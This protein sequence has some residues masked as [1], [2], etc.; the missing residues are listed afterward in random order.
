MVRNKNISG[1]VVFYYCVS[2]QSLMKGLR[3]LCDD[4]D[5][6][7]M[8][9]NLKEHK[10]V[11]VY[12]VDECDNEEGFINEVDD[13]ECEEDNSEES[14][15]EE[16][17]EKGD[18]EQSIAGSLDH[19]SCDDEEL[20]SVRIKHLK[21]RGIDF[22]PP[23]CVV[24]EAGVLVEVGEYSNPRVDELQTHPI[25]T[26]IP[27]DDDQNSECNSFN[28]LHSPKRHGDDYE[29]D[30]TQTNHITWDP[31]SDPFTTVFVKGMK[32][33]DAAT[34][35]EIITC[36]AVRNGYGI[37]YEK[38]STQVVHARCEGKCEFRLFANW[39]SNENSFQIKSVTPKHSCFRVKEIKI[40]HSE[41]L[42]KYFRDE[43]L[44][45]PKW[46]V[47]DFVKE[48]KL[49]YNIE[50]SHTKC[51]VAKKIVL[52]EMY[53]SLKN[54]YALLW[55]YS[56]ELRRSNPDGTFKIECEGGGEG[57]VPIFKRFYVG[58]SALSKG[59][60][61]GCRPIIGID[62]CF[63]KGS[64]KGEILAAVG[65]DANNQLFPIAWAVVEVESKDSWCWF[66]RYLME[67]I[68]CCEDGNGLTIC[69]DQQKGLIQA[70]AELLPLAEHRNCARHI[71]ENF[72]KNF[73]GVNL[74]L[75]FWIAARAGTE[76]EWKI[77]MAAIKRVT[78]R[79][80]LY[81]T[82]THN[83]K[84]WAR[85]F[86]Q[87]HCVCEAVEN[88]MSECFNAAIIE[89]RFKLIVDMLEDIRLYVCERMNRQRKK[90]EKW[91]D[92]LC[93]QIRMKLEDNKEKQRFWTSYPF[94]DGLYEVK[95]RT[96]GFIVNFRKKSCTCRMWNLS[97][98]PCPHAIS[99]IYHERKQPEDFVSDWLKKEKH[100]KAYA[101]FMKPING[102]LLWPLCNK[103]ILP[104]FI[105]K[106]P[107]RPKNKR[108]KSA[109]E[110]SSQARN[111]GTQPLTQ[112]TEETLPTQETLPRVG[113]LGEI[114]KCKIC[115]EPGHNRTTCP[116]KGTPSQGS[117]VSSL[118]HI[119][120]HVE[121]FLIFS[122]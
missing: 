84:Y 51:R 10:F 7:E 111:G 70:V 95:H 85:A 96:D 5:C 69:S 90:A 59:W 35:K 110:Q 37:W 118:L 73:T 64:V 92:D 23:N 52:S 106:Q 9:D 11:E 100:T 119:Y 79:G 78:P 114:K 89:A 113:R 50:V 116:G 18:E 115:K 58:F 88:N 80:Y 55:D 1:N 103:P 65:R 77:P 120:I 101:N 76:A 63:L 34:L 81:L 14:S 109:S 82:E 26:P 71:Y 54:H 38:S 40:V 44:K 86:F 28:P 72:Y 4:K 56:E 75:N 31:Q 74:K 29:D 45:N 105:R 62:G 33:S 16:D 12:V 93:P 48:V 42:A 60:R 57:G 94:G 91:Q 22:Q 20:V 21:H 122:N 68:C 61:E 41:W 112:G 2:G 83:P 25:L 32:F 87:T 107:G 39:M 98:I 27:H 3:K 17:E 49:R 99:A 43:I 19:M 102:R 46:R 30:V 104:P 36:I 15:E 97:G 24:N 108:R 8:L 53:E 13:H 47:R 121:F 6:L 66:L 67:D 117:N